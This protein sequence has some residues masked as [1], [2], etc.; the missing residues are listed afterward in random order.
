MTGKEFKDLLPKGSTKLSYSVPVYSTR[1][2]WVYFYDENEIFLQTI[3]RG[4]S[5]VYP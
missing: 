5:V 4:Y 3:R 2:L 1:R